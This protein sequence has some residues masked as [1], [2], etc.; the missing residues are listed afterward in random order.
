MKDSKDMMTVSVTVSKA[1]KSYLLA[2]NEGSDIIVPCR[3]SRL[4]GLVKTHLDL[5]PH[6][7]TP[8]P[9]SGCED[10][11]RIA[12]HATHRR[13]Y[14]YPSRKVMVTDSLWRCHINPTGQRVIA[15]YLSRFFK[16]SFR[17][18]MTGALA[19]NDKLKIHDAILNFCQLHDIDMDLV[20]YEMLRK[21]WYRFRGRHPEGSAIPIENKDF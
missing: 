3:E 21:D 11:I 5:I 17:S 12:V 10:A 7:Y 15:D 19:N 20:T 1:L 4:W 13:G 8:V 18:Y 6:D 14:N 9:A 16:H 2:V